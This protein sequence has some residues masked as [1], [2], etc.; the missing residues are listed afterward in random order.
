MTEPKRDTQTVT[1]EGHEVRAV[2]DGVVIR[3]IVTLTDDRGT[4][5]ELFH[6]SWG[7][8]E[9]PL[10]SAYSCTIRPGV[11]KGW[12]IHRE[13]EDRY[14]MIEG[15]LLVVL[16]DERPD[17]PTYG[18]VSEIVLSEQRRQVMNIPIGVWH[19]DRNIGLKDARIINFPTTPYD[20]EN[21]DKYRLPLNN[22]RI[23][24]RFE[25]AHGW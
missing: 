11:V 20:H 16:Y 4:L 25:D 19:A 14:A 1:P 6:P 13:H 12:A 21:P 2:P 22:D 15:E 9:A 5:F 8:T 7:W 24:Y 18:L 17:S 3:D 10:V 23:P